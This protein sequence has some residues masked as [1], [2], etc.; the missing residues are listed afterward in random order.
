MP[1]HQQWDHLKAKIQAASDYESFSDVVLRVR[2]AELT[3][4]RLLESVKQI[5]GVSHREG[6]IT[7]REATVSTV[8]ER[9]R[10]TAYSERHQ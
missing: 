2:L 7:G 6:E 5:D 9:A 10:G 3:H 4:G 1:I 8:G